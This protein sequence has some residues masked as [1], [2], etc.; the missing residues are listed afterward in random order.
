MRQPFDL[1]PEHI[2][3]HWQEKSPGLANVFDEMRKVESWTLDDE[4]Q[5]RE[6]LIRFG[7]TL[8]TIPGAAQR[9]E[10]ARRSDMLV[11][12]VYLRAEVSVYLLHQLDV[13]FDGLGSRILTALL[14]V[15]EELPG[16]ETLAETLARQLRLLNNTPFLRQVFDPVRVKALERA[17]N[18]YKS[19][20]Q[21]A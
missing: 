18:Q 19:G 11:F 20:D 14:E 6:R 1:D 15:A 10:F 12:L 9:L 2:S 8:G 13:Q 17:I 3:R 21:Y 16:Q 7:N 5:I 4:P